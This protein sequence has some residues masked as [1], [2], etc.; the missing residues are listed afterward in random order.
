MKRGK[1]IAERIGCAS[2]RSTKH[3]GRGDPGSPGALSAGR[4]RWGAS[5]GEETSGSQR[6]APETSRSLDPRTSAPSTRVDGKGG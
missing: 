6:E 4:G 1:K 3:I 2:Q 5:R